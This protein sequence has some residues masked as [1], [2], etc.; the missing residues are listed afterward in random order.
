MLK[1]KNKSMIA[2]IIVLFCIA[3]VVGF[4]IFNKALRQANTIGDLTKVEGAKDAPVK[5]TEYIDF[6]CPSCAQGSIYL[7]KLMNS[8]SNFIR[9]ELKYYPLN[10]HRHAF[11]SSRYAECAARQEKF[12][13]F[14]DRILE[15]QDQW[16]NLVDVVPTFDAISKE[17]GLDMANLK[18]CLNDQ[19]VEKLI[20]QNKSEGSQLGVQ[21]TPSYFIN[22]KMVV[23]YKSMVSELDRL[24]G[25]VR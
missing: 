12:W 1:T 11:R 18:T 9:L 20:E 6:Q 3:L 4:K 14:H 24:V 22:G 17:I 16:R 2:I 13:I 10:I 8:N 7:K 19:T 21:S 5:I 15:R 25:E 23:G